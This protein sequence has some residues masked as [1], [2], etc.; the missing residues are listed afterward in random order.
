MLVH[1][2]KLRYQQAFAYAAALLPCSC[3]GCNDTS[4]KMGAVSPQQGARG[5]QFSCENMHKVPVCQIQQ[6]V[7]VQNVLAAAG[8]FEHL[9]NVNFTR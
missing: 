8:S 3:S 5:L 1:F 6:R 9:S 4:A 7:K 2:M